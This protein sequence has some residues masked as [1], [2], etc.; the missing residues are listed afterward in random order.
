MIELKEFFEGPWPKVL[1]AI[2]SVAS[3]ILAIVRTFKKADRINPVFIKRSTLLLRKN[4]I[5]IENL[6]I[7]YKGQITDNFTATTI[8]LWNDGK[9]TIENNDIAS[10]NSLRIIA[11]EGIKIFECTLLHRSTPESQFEVM[12]DYETNTIA[13]HFEY[14]DSTQGAAIRIYHSGSNSEDVDVTG[15]FK[16]HGKIV[17]FENETKKKIIHGILE[18]PA[19]N[20][21]P[22]TDD[23]KSMF[24]TF[25]VFACFFIGVSIFAPAIVVAIIMALHGFI[26][27]LLGLA[28]RFTIKIPKEFEF[29]EE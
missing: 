21:L 17:S 28:I 23:R 7:E 15:T 2:I 14:L 9:R 3:I 22:S 27:V 18:N 16:S 26:Y 24:K 20:F 6:N 19:K 13:I 5:K 1:A 10:T 25:L 11:A 8:V 12:P 29:I 4:I